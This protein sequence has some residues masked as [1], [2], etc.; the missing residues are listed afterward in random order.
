LF[1]QKIN[2]QWLFLKTRLAYV[3]LEESVSM[4]DFFKELKDT[5]NQLTS[6]G[7]LKQEDDVVGQI[8]NSLLKSCELLANNFDLFS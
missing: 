3:R 4:V 8:F 6:I 2:V 7:E 1:K 5:I